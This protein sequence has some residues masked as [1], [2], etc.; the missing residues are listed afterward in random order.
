MKT[1]E[2]NKRLF[3]I[4][5]MIDDF[6]NSSVPLLNN[7]QKFLESI[8][9]VALGLDQEEDSPQRV[10]SLY[11]DCITISCDSVS[12]MPQDADSSVSAVGFVVDFA[13]N[14]QADLATS[15]FSRAE[16]EDQAG[17]DAVYYSL[18]TFIDLCGG[19]NVSTPINIV[20]SNLLVI[21]QLNAHKECEDKV[22]KHKRDAT[23]EL[24]ESLPKTSVLFSW[25]PRDSTPNLEKARDIARNR[26]GI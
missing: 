1:D 24:A 9:K 10:N 14:E 7:T 20:S 5:E 8:Q 2:P 17:Y 3:A 23:L 16:T 18:S 11:G 15:R 6:F 22:L 26:L 25:K 12:Y 19:A 13:K 4:G 21:D